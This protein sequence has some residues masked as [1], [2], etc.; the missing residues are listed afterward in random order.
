[1]INDELKKK[2]L[3]FKKRFK[4]Y[5]GDHLS[6]DFYIPCLLA[7]NKL[8]RATCDFTS[9]VLYQY[10]EALPKLVDIENDA[11]QI[12][13]LA[14]P[15]LQK[16]DIEILKKAI[17]KKQKEQIE[18][19][20]IDGIINDAISIAEGDQ[21]KEKIFKVFAWLIKHKRMILKFAILT[22]EN[23][24]LFHD[25]AG[26]FYLNLDDKKIG[27]TGSENET[28]SGMARNGGSFTV[29]KSWQPV[30]SDYLEDIETTFDDAW[31]DKLPLL[32]TKKLNNKILDK[33]SKYAP[34]DIKKFFQNNN[35]KTK[36]NWFDLSSNDQNNTSPFINSLNNETI[37]KLNNLASIK[38]ELPFKLWKHQEKAKKI[39][40]DSKRGIL[41]M[42][43]GT[44]KTKTALSILKSLIDQNKIDS[45]I[46]STFGT[47]LLNQWHKE[48]LEFFPFINQG[49]KFSKIF[50]SYDKFKQQDNYLLSPKNSL[51]ITEWRFSL[52]YIL[53]NL[54][55][56]Q[57]K[58][59]LI[60]YDEIHGLGAPKN[61]ESLKG[62]HKNFVYKLGLSATPEREYGE[63][64]NNF[65]LSEIG[66]II[67]RYELTNA[68]KDN[69]LCEFEYVH[70]NYE[71][72]DDERKKINGIIASA[73]SMR[74]NGEY[75]DDKIIARRI[76]NV[77][78]KA[79]EKFHEFKKILEKD[80]SIINSCIIFVH[81]KNCA[82]KISN[83]IQPFTNKYNEFFDDENE[84]R[85][86]NFAQ[87][88]LDCLI[89]CHKLSQGIDIQ[90]LKNIVIIS[91]DKSK[92]ETIQRI[93]RCL[94]KNIKDPLKTARV[95]DFICSDYKTDE[96]R[97]N[98]LN[99]ISKTKNK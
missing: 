90:G 88:N 75:V 50:R 48:I 47:P 67:D 81:T 78:K 11:C 28:Y 32:K 68:I 1:M 91:S 80:A 65:I 57:Q 39:F 93:G 92:L 46:I 70:A 2:I 63:D 33:I 19:K 76:S 71:L 59:T 86:L 53:K 38:K 83:I 89:S 20:I 18:D 36:K 15:K 56:D 3:N 72:L 87:G 12:Q 95:V 31:N 40:L 62:L 42:A 82:K 17:D 37:K 27:F 69:I 8:K 16:K 74:K 97:K 4:S 84:E 58:K 43:T 22:Q 29:Y 10:G 9:S 6:K 66:P 5:A 60:I 73:E 24:N 52:P 13:I 21:N 26:V 41:E 30:E 34:E 44:G 98:W 94:R 79:E 55:T 99:E 45:C 35:F 51:I 85:L 54:N 96:E 77:Y 64:G 49:E 25:K 7:S 61:I 14:E 23:S